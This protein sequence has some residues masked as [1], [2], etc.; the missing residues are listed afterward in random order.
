MA[1]FIFISLENITIKVLLIS[2]FVALLISCI[3]NSQLEQ[4]KAKADILLNDISLGKAYAA[5][6]EKYFTREQ[7]HALMDEL[8]NKCDFANRKGIFINDYTQISNGIKKVSFIYEY[9]L[10]CD[11]IRFILT[12]NLGKNPELYEFK[13]EPIEKDNPMITISQKRLKY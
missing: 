3:N 13:L 12:Y 6:P 1:R 4:A 10:K 2:I 9:Y 11:S 8:K 5:F 7:T